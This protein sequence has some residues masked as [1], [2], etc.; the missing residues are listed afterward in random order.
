MPAARSGA[1]VAPDVEVAEARGG[2]GVHGVQVF[3]R[4]K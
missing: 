4:V 1:A 3:Q 2:K